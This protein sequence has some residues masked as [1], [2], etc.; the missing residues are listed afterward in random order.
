METWPQ[1]Y[2]DL[3][4]PGYFEFTEDKGEFVF[5]AMRGWLDVRV[6]TR[7][8]M[9]EFTWQG[10]WE[11]DEYCGR[12]IFEFPDPDHGEGMFFIHSGDESAVKIER[13]T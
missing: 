11:R 4:E 7:V 12:G 6:S 13:K 1:E 10:V 2:V 3:E 9:L 5:G 8:P